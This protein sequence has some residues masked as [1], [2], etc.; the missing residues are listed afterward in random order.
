MGDA[1]SRVE[2]CPILYCNQGPFYI[3]IKDHVILQ[4]R[5][6]FVVVEPRHQLYELLIAQNC[7]TKLSGVPMVVRMYRLINI[8]V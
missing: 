6:I 1:Y 4:S 2:P 7:L 5:T 3:T 8:P